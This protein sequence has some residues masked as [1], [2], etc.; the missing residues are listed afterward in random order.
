VSA[1]QLRDAMIEIKGGEAGPLEPE[2]F[3]KLLRQ[4][5]D[6][7]IIDLSK[8]DDGA[9]AVKLRLGGG[10]EPQAEEA[11]PA[12][13]SSADPAPAV[14]PAAGV[15][16]RSARFR[17]GSK[18]GRVAAPDIPKIGVV[19]VDPN[20]KPRIELV[21]AGRAAVDPPMPSSSAPS[22][23]ASRGRV[24]EDSREPRRG[25]RGSAGGG[26]DR[27]RRGSGGGGQGGGGRSS[28][29]GRER[30]EREPG[31]RGRG[32]RGGRGRGGSR[33]SESTGFERSEPREVREVPIV[34]PV[35]VAAAPPPSSPP[36][37]SEQDS[38]ESFWTKVKRGLTGGT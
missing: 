7:E 6:A 34:R 1:E 18:G 38:G 23:T 17:R 21:P 32:R 28:S 37:P 30:G 4:A 22:S 29:S 12:A 25:G 16:I 15:P 33:T 36:P 35:P 11:A 24:E 13:Q 3:P 8:V 5:Q 31:E 9:Y 19:E 2:R 20:F 27:S 26:G 14:S 10:T